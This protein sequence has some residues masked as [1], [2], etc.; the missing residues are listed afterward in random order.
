MDKIL[1]HNI[2]SEKIVIASIISDVNAYSEVSQILSSEMFYDQFHGILYKE[3]EKQSKQGRVPDIIFLSEKF[4]NDAGSISR[5]VDISDHYSIDYYDHALNIQEKF[6]R[7]KLWAIGAQLSSDVFL[8]TKETQELLVSLQKD[9]SLINQDVSAS[10]I[11][12]LKDA[13]DGVYRQIENNL[14]GEQLTGTD[15]GFIDLNKASGGLQGSDLIIIAG[16]TSSGKTSMALALVDA[17]AKQGEGVAVY[18]MEMKKEQCAARLLSMNSGVPSSQILFTRLDENYIEIIDQGVNKIYNLPVYFDDNSTSN[19]DNIIAS[20]RAMKSKHNI[21]GAVVD[22]LQI[23]NV[24][25]KSMNKEQA[26]G[27]VARRLKNLAKE[28]D[29][30]IIALSQLNRDAQNPVPNLNRL[31]DSGQIAEAADIVMFI[32][33]PELYGKFY[34]EPFS[35]HNTKGTALIDIAKGR[36]IGLLKFICTFDPSTTHFR[37]LSNISLCTEITPF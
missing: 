16:E 31:R 12:T 5:I 11:T 2:D 36:N 23:L 18:S 4:R 29:I 21:S 33:R 8:G 24:N 37:E 27:D 30:W 34:Q 7:R 17:A 22:Y 3:I 32:Y 19:I 10:E 13:I 15:T 28:L 35:N 1:P 14:N 25:Q 26:M 9:L 6:V 20:I